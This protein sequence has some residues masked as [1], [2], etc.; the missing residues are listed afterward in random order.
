MTVYGKTRP[1]SPGKIRRKSGKVKQKLPIVNWQEC[2][3]LDRGGFRD[4]QNTT[5]QLALQAVVS[6]DCEYGF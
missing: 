5:T 2:R 1:T 4:L 6:P 3:F